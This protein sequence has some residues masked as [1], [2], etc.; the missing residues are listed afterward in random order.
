MRQNPDTE[1][2]D[3]K[4]FSHY[5]CYDH[6]TGRVV[7]RVDRILMEAWFVLYK[8][9]N[10]LALGVWQIRE[11]DDDGYDLRLDPRFQPDERDD[12]WRHNYYSFVPEIL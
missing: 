1:N 4:K 6:R 9:K 12:N 2:G 8:Y 10:K 11:N 7:W 3:V 5:V